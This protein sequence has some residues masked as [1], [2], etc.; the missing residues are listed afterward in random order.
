MHRYRRICL[1]LLIFR[2]LAAQERP[3]ATPL[4]SAAAAI[5][6]DVIE[7]DA[8]LNSIRLHRAHDIA[9]R[10][11]NAGGEPLRG[12]TVMFALPDSGPSA[13]FPDGGIRSTVQTDDQGRAAARGI[14]PN[15]IAGQ[16][17]IRVTASWRGSEGAATLVQTNAEP[18][19]RSGRTKWIVILAA[20]AGAAAG[21]A[22]LAA[23][24]KSSSSDAATP[25][26]GSITA[27]APIFGPPH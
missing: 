1:L 3:A 10:V 18:E 2:V 19:V 26:G 9:V 5:R 23:R 22:V 21:G 11:T 14:R 27:G 25:T 6:I 12:I 8:A 24:G 4:A 20:V 15:S 17:Q 13:T 16:F 7:G